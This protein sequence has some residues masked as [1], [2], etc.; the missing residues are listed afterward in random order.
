[1]QLTAMC[2]ATIHWIWF[3]F[4]SFSF[5]VFFLFLFCFVRCRSLGV[6]SRVPIERLR[7][8]PNRRNRAHKSAANNEPLE[9]KQICFFFFRLF[10]FISFA[11]LHRINR[12]ANVHLIEVRSLAPSRFNSIVVA[13][14]RSGIVGES[15][16]TMH[17][18][19]R[20]AV[21][22]CGRANLSISKRK[23]IQLFSPFI[24]SVFIQATGDSS[25]MH[26]QINGIAWWSRRQTTDM[27]ETISTFENFRL[28][29]RYAFGFD[30][31]FR[32]SHHSHSETMGK[33][34]MRMRVHNEFVLAHNKITFVQSPIVACN[35]FLSTFY[36][37]EILLREINVT[38]STFD[39]NLIKTKRKF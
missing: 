27:S 5:S 21:T 28:V 15:I 36:A 26:V 20:D 31:V 10:F 12:T 7:H 17:N 3:L 39:A 32:L 23:T 19:A 22:I 11:L 9:S 33:R 35:F 25:S 24:H 1:M 4:F 14:I 8:S 37:S 38:S 16:V 13:F 30:V 6:D 34:T 29:I 18:T 2:F